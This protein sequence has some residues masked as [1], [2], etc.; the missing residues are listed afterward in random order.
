[1]PAP[2]RKKTTKGGAMIPPF[3]KSVR[4]ETEGDA[5]GLC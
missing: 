1:L 3:L 2:G 5:G 4:L